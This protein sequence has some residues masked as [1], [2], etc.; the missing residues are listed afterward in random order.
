M[1]PSAIGVIVHTTTSGQAKIPALTG[2]RGVAAVW[3]ALFHLTPAA[4]KL[5]G[6]GSPAGPL[7][8]GYLGVDLFFL[9]SGFVLGMTYATPMSQAWR[10]TLKRFA[11]GRAFR[12]LPLHWFVLFVLL[13]LTI[14]WPEHRWGAGRHTVSTFVAC[15]LLVQAWFQPDSWSMAWNYPAWSL[16]TEWFAYF[17]FPVMAWGAFR[18]KRGEVALALSLLCLLLLCAALVVLGDG[19]LQHTGRLA[20]P[21]CLAEFT[22]GLLLWRARDL[23]ALRRINGDV[24]FLVGLAMV[25]FAASA[26]A[27]ELVA[28][29]GF[30]A[31]IV[32]CASPA[33]APAMVF[34]SRPVE[35]LGEISFSLYLTHAATMAVFEA[36][37]LAH[38]LETAPWGARLALVAAL[39]VA[40]LVVPVLTWRFIEIPGQALGRRL[41]R[42][43]P[44]KPAEAP[45]AG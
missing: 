24:A 22:A 41:R 9:L 11:V 13:A 35:F 25:G 8:R 32:G 14:L 6:G 17:L 30:A 20:E 39:A 5:L 36:V 29:F 15:L 37:I 21:R 26:P 40:T 45:A 16:S 28:P 2:I 42:A 12:I 18:M 44:P 19:G 34:G 7:T 3:V 38:H 10:P 27:F 23:G 31:L 33:R 43:W 4:A 1:S